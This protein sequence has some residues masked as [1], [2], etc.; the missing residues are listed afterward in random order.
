MDITIN[1]Y[2]KEGP[3]K[4]G[5]RIYYVCACPQCGNLRR[6]RSDALDRIKSCH[7]CHHSVQ[8]P[9]KPEGDVHWCNK[10]K[11]WKAKDNFNFRQDGKSRNCKKCEDDYRRANLSKINEYCKKYKKKNIEQTMLSAAKARSKEFGL[12]FNIDISDIVVPDLCPVLGMKLSTEGSKQNSPSLD[13]IFP[14]YGYT[15]GNVRVISWRA[16]WIKNNATPEEIEKLFM[17]SISIRAMQSS[18]K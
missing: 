6:V 14:E 18:M 9:P 2:I 15:K 3:I 16:N 12:Q 4:E 7:P 13:R 1:E 5:R 10:C 8:R 11:S 17:D